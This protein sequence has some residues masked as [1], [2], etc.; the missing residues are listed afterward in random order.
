[1][2]SPANAF[3]GYCHPDLR[4]T[5]SR[6]SRPCGSRQCSTPRWCRQ[7][8]AGRGLPSLESRILPL[9]PRPNPKSFNALRQPCRSG[10]KQHNELLDCLSLASIIDAVPRTRSARQIHGLQQRNLRETCRRFAAEELV[11]DGLSWV[12]S[13]RLFDRGFSCWAAANGDA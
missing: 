5:I 4:H 3:C 13:T 8:A 6:N 9:T 10:G 11:A 12:H 2:L 7:L 1:M